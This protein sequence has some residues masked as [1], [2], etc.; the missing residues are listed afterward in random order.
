MR[1]NVV[2]YLNVVICMIMYDNGGDE[3]ECC[4]SFEYYLIIAEMIKCHKLLNCL[5]TKQNYS[6]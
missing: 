2:S 6:R 4:K 3:I 5:S 1:L